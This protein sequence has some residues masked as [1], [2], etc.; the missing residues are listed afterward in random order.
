M[1]KLI[2]I[3]VIAFL[4]IGNCMVAAQGSQKEYLGLPGDNLNLYAVMDLFQSAETLEA[5]ERKLNDPEQ[6]V[7]NLDLNNDNYV[8]Y[9]MVLDYAEDDLHNIVLRVALNENEYQDVAV[10]V[11][12]RFPNGSVQIQLIGDETL[13]GPSYIVEPIYA[14]TPNPGYRGNSVYIAETNYDGPAVST[15]FYEVSQWP[16][17]VYVYNPYYRPWHSA[18]RWGYYPSYWNPWHPHYWHYYYGYH[19]HWHPHYYAHYRHCRYHR[20]S[21]YQTVYYSR[22]R[23]TSSTVVVNVNNGRYKDTYTRPETRRAGEQIAS[24]RVSERQRTTS[25]TASVN[26]TTR[27]QDRTKVDNTTTR[28]SNRNLGSATVTTPVRRIDNSRRTNATQSTRVSSR[29]TSSNASSNVRSE[30]ASSQRETSGNNVRQSTRQSNTT[31]TAKPSTQR[32]TSREVSNSSS[33]SNKGSSTSV[34][35]SN[36]SSSSSST[37]QAKPS[38]STRSSAK[39]SSSSSGNSKSSA[40]KS[41]SGSSSKTNSNSRTRSR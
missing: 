5:F 20:S 11:V 2:Y 33:N 35:R 1:K 36:P 3:S 8:D 24:Q 23:R 15:T 21:R 29:N 26:S 38:Q 18:W 28:V 13:Y 19:S 30:N 40:T 6:M 22:V 41:E 16:I 17:V 14:E 4:T 37:Q 12:E 7:N 34:S 39:T 31:T 9:I 32:T 27:K 25:G 10:I